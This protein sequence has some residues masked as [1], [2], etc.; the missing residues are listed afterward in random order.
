MQASMKR[1]EQYGQY[2][3]VWM[4]RLFKLKHLLEVWNVLSVGEHAEASS[5][6]HSRSQS[7]TPS[8]DFDSVKSACR[9]QAFGSAETMFLMCHPLCL[10]GWFT[11]GWPVAASD[12]KNYRKG[13]P[14][15]EIHWIHGNAQHVQTNWW[16]QLVGQKATDQHTLLLIIL[17]LFAHSACEPIESKYGCIHLF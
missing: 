10:T 14:T 12:N 16:N 13:Q 5:Q 4:F 15:M 9:R 1:L 2:G 6:F 17:V 3:C 8:L 11:I 7:D